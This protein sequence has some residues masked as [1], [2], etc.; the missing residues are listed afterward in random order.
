[1]PSF[2]HRAADLVELMDDPACDRELLFRTYAQF[3]VI[4]PLL[5]R[6][7]T[8]YRRHLR[9]LMQPGVPFRLLDIGFGGGDIPR[10]LDRWARRD[11]LRLEITAIDPDPRA[12][13]FA[14]RAAWPDTITFRAC[15]TATLRAEGAR[16]DAVISNAVLHHLNPDAVTRLLEDSQALATRLVLHNDTVRSAAA[17][18]LFSTFIAPWFRRSFT[19]EDGRRTIRR[20]Y[21]PDELL[22]LAPPG[23]R[24]EPLFP[25]RQ[26][27][28]WEG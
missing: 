21:R 9:P 5:S 25:F 15:D 23:W 10:R 26:L 24:I 6:W 8:V 28:V 18:A 22:A 2:Q 11:G 19:A 17:Y 7:R 4:N 27:A 20:S 16:F 3:A 13:D 14:A 12:A 1:M